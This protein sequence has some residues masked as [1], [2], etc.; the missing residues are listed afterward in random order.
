MANMPQLVCAHLVFKFDP[1]DIEFCDIDAGAWVKNRAPQSMWLYPAE[2]LAKG[3]LDLNFVALEQPLCG[4]GEFVKIGFR[5]KS[6]IHPEIGLSL[7][8]LRDLHCRQIQVNT[9]PPVA[10]AS[11]VFLL[12]CYPNPFNPGTE[13]RYRIPVGGEGNYRIA[14]FDLRGRQVVELVNQYHQVGNYHL[15][16]NGLNQLGVP[17]ASGVYFVRV[18][19]QKINK[20]YKI[21]LMR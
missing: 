9:Q 1:E 20:N 3:Y 19:G 2:Q 14:L 16:W 12:N 15:T 21:T 4:A 6:E 10:V 11:E 17:V 5:Q 18:S 8:D 13:L 7:V